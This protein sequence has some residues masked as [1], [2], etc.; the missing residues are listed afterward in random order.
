MQALT[1]MREPT[2]GGIAIFDY[3]RDMPSTRRNESIQSR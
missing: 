3:A 1:T 2:V